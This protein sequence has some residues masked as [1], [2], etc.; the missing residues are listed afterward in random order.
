[1]ASK[2]TMVLL[3]VVTIVGPEARAAEFYAKWSHGPSEDKSFFPIAVWLQSPAK[4]PQYR[5]TGINIYV[6][7]WRGP[8]D[9]QLQTLKQAG[10]LL[11]CN[12]FASPFDDL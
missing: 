2:L 10:M 8:T 3:F 5:E 1:M 12:Q 4:A 11:I 9:E 7:L 6:A